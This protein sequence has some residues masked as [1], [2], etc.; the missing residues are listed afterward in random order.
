MSHW[1]TAA[2]VDV[3][4]RRRWADGSL[5]REYAG[6]GP[7]EPIEIPLRGPRASEIGDDLAAV[8]EWVRRLDDGSRSDS[9]YSLRWASVGGRSIGRNQVPTR[10]VVASFE[11]AWSLLGVA[12]EVRRFEELLALSQGRPAVRDWV[13]ARPHQALELH[14]AMP[15]LLAAYSWLD[16]HRGSG[17][18][19]RE[20]T[21]PGVDTKFAEQHRAVLAAMLGVPATAAGFVSGLGLC[22]K[23]E[24]ARLRVSDSLGLPAPLTELSVRADEL[25]RLEIKPGSALVVENEITYLSV[26]VP[27]DGVVLWGK[28][29]EVDRVGG[30]PWL[31]D[32]E[33]DY[34]G[35]LDTHG[36]AILDRLRAWLPQTRSLLMDRETLLAHRDRWVAEDRPT[37]AHLTRLTPTEQD[38]YTDLVSDAFGDSVRLEQER[39]DWAWASGRLSTSAG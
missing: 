15:T 31:T 16:T 6:G 38:L 28:G 34:W 1:S 13:V 4:V 10:A 33:V 25:A 24:F 35:D 14:E 30:L 22:A 2:D 27:Q 36:F 23:P 8:R 9:R 37:S 21:A 20:I 29:F 18:Y 5:L 11:Q 12:G 39:V 32:V 17:R 3:K 7:L 26:P 19:L